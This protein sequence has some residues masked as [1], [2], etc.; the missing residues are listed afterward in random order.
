[1]TRPKGRKKGMETVDRITRIEAM[2]KRLN[3]AL[4]A[5]RALERA[6]EEFKSS[7]K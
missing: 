4:A 7:A 5:V 2:E 6:L 1:M 3:S